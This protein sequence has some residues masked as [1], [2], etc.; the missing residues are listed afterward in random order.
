MYLQASE[1]AHTGLVGLNP[2]RAQRRTSFDYFYVAAAVVVALLVV[3]WAF[4]G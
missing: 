4:L 3:V 2:F 1:L